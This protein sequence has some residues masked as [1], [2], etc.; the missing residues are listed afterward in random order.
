MSPTRRDFLKATGA[1][2]ASTAFGAELNAQ[3]ASRRR[4]AIV[5]TGVRA[6]GMWGRPLVSRFADRLEFVGLCDINPKRV[7][8][9]RGHRRLVPDLHGLR[10]VLRRGA[11]RRC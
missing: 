8:L 3:Q 7:E 2:A 1:I 4:Y 5:G 6:I 10:R 11:A 9:H